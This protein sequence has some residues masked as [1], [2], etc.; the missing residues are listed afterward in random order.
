MATGPEGSS[1]HS[2]ARRLTA[3]LAA[4]VVGYS[5][6]MA[7][8]EVGA[9]NQL[10]LLRGTVVGPL[11]ARYRG[12]IVGSAG[13]SFLVAFSSAVDAVTCAIAWQKACTE[14]ANNQ[15]VDQQMLFRIGIHLGDVIPESGTIYG[16]GVNIAARL[17]KLA[18]PGGLVVSRAIRDQVEGRLD[19]AFTE[20]G[21]QELKNIARPIEAFEVRR[22]D[23]IAKPAAPVAPQ[24]SASAKLSI[25][26][27]PFSNMSGDKEQDYF[28]D[29]ITEDIITEISRFR[30]LRVIARNS[31]FAFRGQN[32]EVGEIARKL[33]V[34]FV[35]EG[36]V[37]KA[38]GRLRITAQLIEAQSDRH[39]WAERYDRSID[40]IF[41]TQDEIARMVAQT[42]A[43]H[44]QSDAAARFRARPTDSLSAYDLVLRARAVAGHYGNQQEVESLLERAIALDPD[45]AIA[46]AM[47]AN[48]LT[49]QSEYDR[50]HERCER[51]AG[52]A[53]R[54]IQL[55]PDEAWGHSM[56]GYSLISRRRVSE[57]G[58]HFQ[59]A[60]QLNPNDV[61]I[62]MYH[63]FWFIFAGQI[64]EALARLQEGL[65]R[66]PFGREWYWDV[67]S[68]ALVVAGRYREAIA[69]FDKMTAPGPWSFLYAAIAQVNLGDLSSA[70]SLVS[71]YRESD[72]KLSP[73]DW[74]SME[75]YVDPTVT[76]RLLSDLR[77][78][79]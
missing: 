78:A 25:A 59:R 57:A 20:L 16:D 76:E 63:A 68:C 54:A 62:T 36:S 32:I 31:S 67:Y 23:A 12:E 45:Y 39:V 5:R 21:R 14:A 6:L 17:E 10:K 37:R 70:R 34:Q 44:A 64:D 65:K 9:L 2:V 18:Q 55:D 50:N 52:F 27:L 35:V 53:M 43:D 26:I 51:A 7:A 41:A 73:E 79:L 48:V 11:V 56:L 13:D 72:A 69:A 1:D 46:H 61:N 38:G 33:G 66:D 58:V 28:S 3:V 15:P 42:V 49:F 75:A 74:I 71:R 60:T 30:E 22:G 29:G 47:M 19:L 40:D 4:D 77:K 24:A 8:D